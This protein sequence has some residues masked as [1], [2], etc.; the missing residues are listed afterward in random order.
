MNLKNLITISKIRRS[1]FKHS[2]LSRNPQLCRSYIGINSKNVVVQ[3][4]YF[5]STQF[6]GIA[7][8]EAKGLYKQVGINLELLPTCPVGLEPRRVREAF[9][10]RKRKELCI[11]I[12]EQNVLIPVLA[13][14]GD[15]DVRAIATMF[16][17]S[18]LCLATI[19]PVDKKANLVIGA[20]ED[21]VEL[22]HLLN[23]HTKVIAVS[24]EEKIS[25]LKKG[26]S[27]SNIELTLHFYTT[28]T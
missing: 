23:P 9:E 25:M 21:T 2:S 14:S 12:I 11:G 24:R 17:R 20:H 4:D 26:L 7:V 8:A 22:L 16:S 5:M 28:I 13:E 1:I 6:A 15:I 3:L 18:P 27:H 10:L 19:R